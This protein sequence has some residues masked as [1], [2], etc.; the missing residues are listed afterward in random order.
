MDS[1]L[2]FPVKRRPR[3]G[4]RPGPA[5]GRRREGK[6]AH[7]QVT[8][9]IVDDDAASVKLVAVVLELE[10]CAVEKASSAEEALARLRTLRPDVV[11][12]DL[13]LPLMSG[14]LLAEQ[15]K[16]AP[17]TRDIPLVAITAFNGPKTERIAAQAGFS[18]FFRKPIDPM[19]FAKDL[20]AILEGNQ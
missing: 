4:K 11:L 7:E 17:E 16:A 3:K 1:Q 2:T 14:V 18:G 9:L 6:R 13:I 19:A 10:G 12:V 8:A 20:F 15:L 5:P